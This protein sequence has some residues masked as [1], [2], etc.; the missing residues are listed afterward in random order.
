MQDFMAAVR[1]SVNRQREIQG[2]QSRLRGREMTPAETAA[3]YR[4]LADTA[5]SR[6]ATGKQLE[7]QDRAQDVQ[8]SQFGERL[9]FDREQ[10]AQQA[11]LERERMAELQRQHDQNLK[12]QKKQME[13]QMTAAEMARQD[14]ASAQKM[15]LATVG[16]GLGMM[17]LENW[18]GG[19]AKGI[20]K[21]VSWLKGLW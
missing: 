8:E 2:R 3:P 21:A 11:T 20:G 1:Q 17:A 4:A 15:Q 19:I 5:T 16:A 14:A 9:E 6:L 7:Q 18:G 12:L 10:S 13:A